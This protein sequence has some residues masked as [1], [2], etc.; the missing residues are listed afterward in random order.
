MK[1]KNYMFISIDMDKAFDKTQHPFMIKTLSQ[2]ELEET[3]LNT[4]KAIYDKSTASII[5]NRQK[6][7]AFPLRSGTRQGC[8]LIFKIVLQVLATANQTRRNQRH[9]N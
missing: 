6:Q 9:P 2:M 1:Y 8:L 5:L 3:Y 4:I 7:Q